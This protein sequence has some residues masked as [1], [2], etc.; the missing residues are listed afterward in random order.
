MVVLISVFIFGQIFYYNKMVNATIR[1]TPLATTSK[2]TASLT[3]TSQQKFIFR[4]Q[5]NEVSVNSN[6]SKTWIESY[7]RNYTGKKELRINT[8][9]ILAYLEKISQEINIQPQNAKL[10]INDDGVTEFEPPQSGRMLD[11][12]ATANKITTAL[13]HGNNK[14]SNSEEILSIELVIDEKQPDV[15]LDKLNNLGINTLLARGESN[16]AGSPKSRV[17][18]ITVGSK[19]FTGIVVKSGEE[20]SFNKLLGSVDASS[21]YLPELVIKKGALIPEY[22]GG[23]C[24]VSTTLFRAATLAGL[25][26][27][28][29]HPHSL[30]VRYYNPQGFD[31]T[32]YPGVSDLRFKNDTPGYILIQAEVVGDQ[33]NFEIYG[34]NDGR[35]TTIDGPNQYDIKSNGS[36]K[37]TLTRTVLYPDGSEKKDVFESSY[38]A[39]GSFPV[40]RNPLE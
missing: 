6:E 19:K 5:D 1:D 33:M 34:T 8:N 7:I 2:L 17:H 10:V 29:R 23:L 11:I 16:F 39:P 24:Q 14:N 15:T 40:V 13:A 22:G 20:F 25:S 31:A 9:K 37:T 32:I 26:I 3:N 12:P 21:G 36:L 4:Y 30:P 27:L 38:K 28:E 18:N 35:K